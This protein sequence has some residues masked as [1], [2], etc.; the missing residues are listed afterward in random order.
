MTKRIEKEIDS[1]VSSISKVKSELISSLKNNNN[2]SLTNPIQ[3][4][5]Q[6]SNTE[7]SE[8]IKI[9]NN[10]ST[11]KNVNNAFDDNSKNGVN[12]NLIGK[13]IYVSDKKAQLIDVS[14]DKDASLDSRTMTEKNKDDLIDDAIASLSKNAKHSGVD[15]KE[16]DTTATYYKSKKMSKE[17]SADPDDLIDDA[18]ASLSKNAKHSGVDEKEIDTTATSCKSKRIS[19]ENSADPIEEDGRKDTDKST[20]LEVG[21]KNGSSESVQSKTSTT[22]TTWPITSSETAQS[23]TIYSIPKTKIKYGNS[24]ISE[25]IP[26]APNVKTFYCDKAGSVCVNTSKGK[27]KKLTDKPSPSTNKSINTSTPTPPLSTAKSPPSSTL[28]QM[29]LISSP[30]VLGNT[31]PMPHQGAIRY[32]NFSLYRKSMY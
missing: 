13:E 15:E 5:T 19:K 6:Q 31:P 2:C 3:K 22:T 32:F 26:N 17:N 24:N 28:P 30:E 7:F 20:D 27:Q 21:E 9:S 23:S 8:N 29:P 16:I 18:I 1:L 25:N 11:S 12:A 4:C 14:R 10:E